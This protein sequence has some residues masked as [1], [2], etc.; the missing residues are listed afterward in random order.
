METRRETDSP[1]RV[2]GHN[3]TTAFQRAGNISH[4]PLI[5]KLGIIMFMQVS[6]LAVA[7]SSQLSM[8]PKDLSSGIKVSIEGMRF[9]T[10]SAV[11]SLKFMLNPVLMSSL[12]RVA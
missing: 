12:L 4:F 1:I 8:P 9:I 6:S 2:Y 11:M 10:F 7:A 3:I 5:F